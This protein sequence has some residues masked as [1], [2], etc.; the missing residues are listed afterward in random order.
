MIAVPL[1]CLWEAA[2][3]VG[4]EAVHRL[5]YFGAKRKQPLHGVTR[6]HGA[7]VGPDLGVPVLELDPAAWLEIPTSD[8]SA[9]RVHLG[10]SSKHAADSL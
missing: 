2:D 1:Q 7:V 9:T 3:I 5:E 6:R 8:P 10:S 4:L